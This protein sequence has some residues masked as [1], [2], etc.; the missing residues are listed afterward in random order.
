MAFRL[1]SCWRRFSQTFCNSPIHGPISVP[2]RTSRC[3]V[4]VSTTVILS[5]DAPMRA[6]KYWKQ[7]SAQEAAR[8]WRLAQVTEGKMFGGVD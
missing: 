8:K 4:G 7:L 2:Y 3:S 5:M 1:P 6:Q